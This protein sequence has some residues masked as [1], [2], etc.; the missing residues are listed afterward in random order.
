MDK[1][2]N[3]INNKINNNMNKMNDKMNNNMNKA[4]MMQRR[5]LFFIFLIISLPFYISEAMAAPM[6]RET[7]VFG[8]NMIYDYRKALDYTYIIT[9]VRTDETNMTA[10]EMATRVKVSN[11]WFHTCEPLPNNFF[12][13]YYTPSSR[14]GPIVPDTHT[15]KIELEDENDEVVAS[16]IVTYHVDNK[17]PEIKSFS[18]SPAVA[19]PEDNISLDFVVEDHAYSNTDTAKC[20]GTAYVTILSGGT[21]LGQLA[22]NKTTCR[23]SMSEKLP[24]TAFTTDTGTTQICLYGTD[25]FGQTGEKK[26]TALTTD[27]NLPELTGFS[28]NLKN[29]SPLYWVNEQGTTADVFL[30]ITEDDTGLDTSNI[31]ADFGNLSGSRHSYKKGS[32][33]QRDEKYKCKWSNVEVK[34]EESISAI[35]VFN[36]SDIAGNEVIT[37][38]SWNVYLD[39]IRPNVTIVAPYI[40]PLNG[41]YYVGPQEM[42]Y[43]AQFIELESGID[44][45]NVFMDFS[46]CGGSGKDQADNCS[47]DQTC[48]WYNR[49][50]DAAD[51]TEGKL[52]ISPDSA[53]NMGNPVRGNMTGD[54]I[55]DSKPP[56]ITEVVMNT[57]GSQWFNQPDIINQ[58]NLTIVVKDDLL[59]INAT[60]Y[61]T[62][63]P[64]TMVYANFT[65]LNGPDFWPGDCIVVSPRKSECL[66]ATYIN[67]TGGRNYKFYLNA[68]DIVGNYQTKELEIFVYRME[69]ESQDLWRHSKGDPSPN[70]IDKQMLERY[71]MFQYWP[72][73]LTSTKPDN[74]PYYIYIADACYNVTT[75]DD[76][77]I[78][79]EDII[80]GPYPEIVDFNT[81]T[82]PGSLPYNMF[83]KYNLYTVAPEDDTV[84]V[85]CPIG[86]LSILD[87]KTI[88]GP[89]IENITI[90]IEYYNLPYGE[91]GDELYEELKKVM[92]GITSEWGEWMDDIEGLIKV[93]EAFC[94]L[95]DWIKKLSDAYSMSVAI[96]TNC[97]NNP[98]S[99]SFCEPARQTSNVAHETTDQSLAQTYVQVKKYCN[100]LSCRYTNE[101]TVK[102]D[103]NKQMG[104]AGMTE[105]ST[106]AEPSEGNT[107]PGGRGEYGTFYTRAGAGYGWFGNTVIKESMIYSIIFLCLPGIVYNG[108]KWRGIECSYADCLMAVPYGTPKYLCDQRREYEQCMFL[109]GQIFNM[110]PFAAAISSLGQNIIAAF[111][112]TGVFALRVVKFTCTGICKEK[113]TGTGCFACNVINWLNMMVDVACDLG[114]DMGKKECEGY[115]EGQTFDFDSQTACEQTIERFE[116]ITKQMDDD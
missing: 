3:R 96:L 23:V 18:I 22:V 72:I 4:H 111:S 28:V 93:L 29:G 30:N 46:V 53:D 88:Y 2:N 81:P 108:Q 109:W 51:G 95:V 65:E 43:Y 6:V 74:W 35:I 13:C 106:G 10:E 37:E 42:D 16:R 58:T 59:I 107:D 61:D 101:K 75:E 31:W 9:E 103:L 110:I 1:M 11:Q 76:E 15:L 114:V 104:T 87:G 112:D 48:F 71:I 45:R 57:T 98:G 5:A 67:V 34:V 92:E 68:S 55:V 99:M 19:G 44:Y 90:E 70:P 105:P 32:C 91:V 84:E 12:K 77:D 27:F 113:A 49:T 73:Q 8:E 80:W 20:V 97:A 60:I 24:A 83:L 66:F 17:A 102:D 115:W 63:S 56:Y 52:R 50:C 33:T 14:D 85:K 100:Y 116:N 64:E 86:I 21:E 54:I 78:S 69:N 94:S 7:H 38:A 47:A 39:N 62:V 36:I 82:E 79:A 25:N 40:M 89:E 41:T 26:C